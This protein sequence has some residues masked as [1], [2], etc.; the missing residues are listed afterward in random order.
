VSIAANLER[1]RNQV[2][3]A[4]AQAHRDSS[5]VALMAVSKSH[6]AEAILEAHA[7]G[8][9]LFG[10]NRVQEFAAKREALATLSIATHLIGPLQSNKA[11]R[12]AELFSAIDSADS[13]KIAQRL[14]T[15][16]TTLGRKLPILVEIKLSPE[17]TKHGLA[18]E[19]LPAFLAAA[20]DLTSLEVQGLMTVPPFFADAEQTRPFFARLRQLRDH[21]QPT[22]PTLTQLSMGMSHDFPI[23]IAEGST[24]VRIGTAIFGSRAYPQT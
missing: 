15:A 7:A 13:L 21:H 14:N 3:D 22:H 9:R 11:A 16:A 2:A 8:Q 4:C 6:P 1:L 12:A 5:A 24:C 23:A 19:E 10:E 20:A 18:P 17:D